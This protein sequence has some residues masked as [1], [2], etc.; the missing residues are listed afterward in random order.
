M[1]TPLHCP[2]HGLVQPI[3]RPTEKIGR[4]QRLCPDCE[5][6]IESARQFITTEECDC[7][8]YLCI[9]GEHHDGCRA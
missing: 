5:A 7:D 6:W 8:C 2:K 3:L 9:R 4:P 1:T